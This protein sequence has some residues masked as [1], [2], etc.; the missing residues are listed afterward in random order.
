MTYRLFLPCVCLAPL[1]LGEV[2]ALPA[3]RTLGAH[4]AATLCE[5]EGPHFPQEKEAARQELEAAYSQHLW[6][7]RDEMKTKHAGVKQGNE[8]AEG[9]HPEG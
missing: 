8:G 4:K 1:A 3:L 7:H 9:N 2:G 6:Q 5:Q